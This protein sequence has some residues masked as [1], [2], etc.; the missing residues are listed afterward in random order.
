MDKKSDWVVTVTKEL[1]QDMEITARAAYKNGCNLR[2][3]AIVLFE[4]GRFP[5]AAALAILAEEEFSKAFILIISAQQGRWDSTIFKSL[6]RH[7]SKQ[8]MSETM[9]NLH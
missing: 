8:A 9:S 1:R 2:Q 4:A 5:R 6:R 7:S 3:D